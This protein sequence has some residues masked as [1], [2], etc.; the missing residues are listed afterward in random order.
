V[1]VGL[2]WQHSPLARR[3]EFRIPNVADRKFFSHARFY[4]FALRRLDSAPH[5]EAGRSEFSS[6]TCCEQV[7]W[8]G[9]NR[10]GGGFEQ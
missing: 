4:S 2:R 10:R 3:V 9:S 7:T 8:Q 1:I 6:A 5:R